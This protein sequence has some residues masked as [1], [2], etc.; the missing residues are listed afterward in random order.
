ML[1]S[2]LISRMG[3]ARGLGLAV[4]LGLV[5]GGAI[6]CFSPPTDDVLFS[7][8]F[9]EDDRCPADY[10]CEPD[11]CC[12]RIGSDISETFGACALGGNSGATSTGMDGTTGETETSGTGDSGTTG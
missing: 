12:H 7:C 2:V 6:A 9:D 11:N 1:A 5:L 3:S 8:E 4:V 10:R